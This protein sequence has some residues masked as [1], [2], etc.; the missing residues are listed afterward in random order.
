MTRTRKVKIYI[1]ENKVQKLPLRNKKYE[2]KN[3]EQKMAQ[4]SL[5][6]KYVIDIWF[7][8]WVKIVYII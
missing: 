1:G 8:Q 4:K 6:V 3:Q 7:K 5:K 2:A